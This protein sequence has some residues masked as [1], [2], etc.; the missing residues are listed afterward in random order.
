[1][2]VAAAVKAGA[3]YL[4]TR[5]KDLLSLGGHQGIRMI[6]PEAFRGILRAA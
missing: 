1:M 6:T 4:V 2:I 5:D 3:D